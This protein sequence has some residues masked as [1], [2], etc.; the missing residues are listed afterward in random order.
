[1][2]NKSTLTITEDGKHISFEVSHDPKPSGHRDTWH[3]PAKIAD[4][5]AKAL[6]QMQKEQGAMPVT[7]VSRNTETGAVN[8]TTRE[9][10]G[11]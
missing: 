7:E 11:E 8:I 3:L 2:T 5:V 10:D 9:K 4:T 6:I 1:M